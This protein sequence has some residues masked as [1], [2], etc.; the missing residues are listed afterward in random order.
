MFCLSLFFPRKVRSSPCKR[1]VVFDLSDG[2]RM[3]SKRA[4]RRIIVSKTN[5]FSI[6]IRSSSV[7]VRVYACVRARAFVRVRACVY[8]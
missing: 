1:R 4:G 7:R 3:Q 2:L 5:E 8:R 6:D